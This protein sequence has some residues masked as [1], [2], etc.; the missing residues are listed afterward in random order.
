[1]EKVGFRVTF[2]Q[3][4]DRPTQLDGENGLRNWIDMFGHLLFEGIPEQTKNQIITKVEA[5]LK[6]ALYQDDNWIADYK[7]IQV[8]GVK[9]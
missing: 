4:Y 8:I 5:N 1:M 6:E 7:R 2:A 3:H 9:E